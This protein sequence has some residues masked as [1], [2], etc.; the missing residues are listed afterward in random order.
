METSTI[1]VIIVVA[2]ALVA[3]TAIGTRFVAFVINVAI[4]ADK[5][6][7]NNLQTQIDDLK[8]ELEEVKGRLEK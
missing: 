7:K 5:E 4:Q 1:I 2:V 8:R 6:K 3:L